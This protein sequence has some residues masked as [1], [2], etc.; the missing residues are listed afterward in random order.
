MAAKRKNLVNFSPE[1]K[2]Y[3]DGLL[4]GDGC[5]QIHYKFKSSP[6]YTQSF[7]KQYKE[8][9]NVVKDKLES[10][11]F[12]CKLYE[13]NVKNE[14]SLR[15]NYDTVLTDFRKRWYP[16]GTKIV[17]KDI[18]LDRGAIANWYLGDGSLKKDNQIIL[19]TNCFSFADVKW[20]SGKLNETVGIL[21]YVK[22]I[23][24]KNLPK[25]QY[26]LAIRSADSI[27]FLDFIKEYN[28]ECFSYKF[29]MKYI[30]TRKKWLDIED[31]VINEK[32]RESPPK[33]AEELNRSLSSIYHRANRL[34]VRFRGY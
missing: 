11:G 7:A 23:R 14:I 5:I 25:D 20:L 3:L 21:S 29:D 31:A 28:I 2:S 22:N 16:N 27:R 9:L 17:P 15:T 34:G 13:R 1:L 32:Y 12:I 19:Y 10:F 24:Y 6:W 18:I 30:S 8:W 26:V 33:I 4:L